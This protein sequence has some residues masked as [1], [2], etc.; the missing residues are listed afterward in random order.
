MRVPSSNVV[1]ALLACSALH[2]ATATVTLLLDG[3]ASPNAHAD[4]STASPFTTLA[5]AVQYLDRHVGSTIVNEAVVVEIA[6]G[7]YYV[8]DTVYITS[9]TATQDC[10]VTFKPQGA[11]RSVVFSGG[12]DVSGF[13][14]PL[15]AGAF[16]DSLISEEAKA[17][18]QEADL[19]G[20]GAAFDTLFD[21]V[22]YHGY[23]LEGTRKKNPTMVYSKG[24][25]M[26]L[27]RWPNAKDMSGTYLAP[28]LDVAN[29][30]GQVSHTGVVDRGYQ[31]NFPSEDKYAARDS[32]AFLTGGG[33]FRTD[34][35]SRTDLWTL[36][37]TRA[38]MDVFLDGV[39]GRSW[40]WTYNQVDSIRGAEVRLVRG[41]QSGLMTGKDPHF[42]FE[43]VPEELDEPGEWWLDRANKKLYIW[44][45][46]AGED[47]S[48]AVLPGS[49]VSM[50]KGSNFVT[51]EGL[52]FENGRGE[53][54]KAWASTDIEVDNC[55]LRNFGRDGIYT[56]GMRTTIKGCEIYNV[57]WTGVE[58]GAT[59][60]TAAE[61]D[62]STWSVASTAVVPADNVIEGC[63]I[64]NFAWDV[65]SQEPGVALGGVGS[66][67]VGN[68]IY[69]GSHFA[70]KVMKGQD[71]VIENN[72]I[73]DLPTYFHE[74]G[75]SLYFGVGM[76]P[77][78]RGN[79]IRGNLFKN[80]P[81][82]GIY[83]DNFSSGVLVERNW[84]MNVANGNDHFGGVDINGGGYNDVRFN[85][86]WK[87]ARPVRYNQFAETSLWGST[88]Y[89][90]SIKNHYDAFNKLPDVASTPYGKYCD[91][92]DFLA[93]NRSDD[94]AF[95]YQSNMAHHNLAVNGEGVDFDLSYVNNYVNAAK[96]ER[97]N[98][99]VLERDPKKW[100][101]FDNAARAVSD[102]A[103]AKWEEVKQGFYAGPMNFR[104]RLPGGTPDLPEHI[105]AILGRQNPKEPTGLWMCS[106]PQ[107]T[108]MVVHSSVN[109]NGTTEPQSVLMRT[110]VNENMTKIDNDIKVE[111]AS[112]DDGSSWFVAAASAACAVVGA[113]I[114]AVVVL[115]RRQ[116]RVS[117]AASGDDFLASS[118]HAIDMTS[119]VL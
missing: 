35:S 22:E 21:P 95:H 25:R 106:E 88:A 116:A 67:A 46:H 98:E 42:H 58:V 73:H 70:M 119:P 29:Y 38:P 40:E 105:A 85:V 93:R 71:M 14:G 26:T 47:V 5:Q 112:G 97:G 118:S 108:N 4:G 78:L 48:M 64:H 84:F 32:D 99:G 72:Y 68:E 50:G 66:R 91:F 9:A 8:E 82:N 39:V 13:L 43:N 69:D 81:T 56:Q 19:S 75:G 55:V 92:M 101:T 115:V 28:S 96:H 62:A 27:A 23:G 52:V 17:H 79:V 111:S 16:K 2:T 34:Y 60:G 100:D 41:E 36:S 51:F 61:V 33:T 31:F 6:A 113:A 109:A 24:E 45:K 7:D 83:L 117:D 76:F 54:I 87:V 107:A 10:P 12:K 49:M 90:S 53:G 15:Q 65:R 74:D 102:V 37:K 103:G 3:S 44:P 77:H 104:N 80:I 57:G 63:T 94:D 114:I 110:A 1:F 30:P 20:L 59:A 89:A 18:V 11:A 86:F